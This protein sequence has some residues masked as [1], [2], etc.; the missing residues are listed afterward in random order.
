RACKR[1]HAVIVAGARGEA[2][3]G[4]PAL[5]WAA[6]ALAPVCSDRLG[7]V[8]RADR[9]LRD[10]RRAG[11]PES[12]GAVAVTS[13]GRE[14]TCV[15]ARGAAAARRGAVGECQNA[16]CARG[17]GAGLAGVVRVCSGRNGNEESDQSECAHGRTISVLHRAFVTSDVPVLSEL[18]P[19]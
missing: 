5:V 7:L 12:C 11:A 1:F 14:G 2:H 4:G 19:D 18:A 13:T 6:V 10:A 15:A 8:G 3:S 16:A 9:S 17:A